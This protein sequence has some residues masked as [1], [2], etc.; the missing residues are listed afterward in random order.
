[1]RNKIQ[2]ITSLLLDSHIDIVLLQETWLNK[3]DS[4]IKCEIED[5][6]LEMIN[7]NRVLRDNG[8]GVAAI[9]KPG[10]NIRQSQNKKMYK[11]FEYICIDLKRSGAT[12]QFFNIYRPPYSQK[13]KFTINHFL[14]EFE[15][16]LEQRVA[17]HRGETVLTGDFNIHMELADDRYAKKFT[18]LLLQ[19]DLTQHVTEATHQEGGLIDLL[20]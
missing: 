18:E 3:G 5:H 7:V 13:H 10:L 12:T 19:F 8:G 4:A 15:C 14:D 17:L 6:D 16:F 9:F 1:M 20:I 11:T 2:D